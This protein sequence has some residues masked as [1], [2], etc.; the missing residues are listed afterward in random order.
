MTA[1]SSVSPI[2]QTPAEFGTGSGQAL[3]ND[4][5]K[6]PNRNHCRRCSAGKSSMAANADVEQCQAKLLMA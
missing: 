3:V 6:G 5:M 2:P 4:V 1:H